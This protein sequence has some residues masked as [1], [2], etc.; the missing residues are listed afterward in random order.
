MKRLYLLRHAKTE[1]AN[2][3]TPADAERPLTERGRMDAPKV[4]RAMRARGY[5]PDL[6]LCSPS[7]RTQQTL[8][9]ANAELRSEAPVRYVD[10]IYA[11]SAARL[12]ALFRGLPEEAQ[13]PLIIGHNP[14]FE[15]G[16][17]LLIASGKSI[18]AEEPDK[19]TFPTSALLILD[20]EVGKWQGL[21]P[22]TATVMDFVRPKELAD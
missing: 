8:Q 2:K 11:A 18:R 4:G 9:L 6:I 14:G 15:D 17:A 16:A 20:F 5:F 12:L 1:Q 7:T 3:D 10:A 13:A 19:L 22:H 21:A